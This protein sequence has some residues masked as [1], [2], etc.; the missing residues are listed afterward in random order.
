MSGSFPTSPAASSVNIKS[1]VKETSNW[2]GINDH[3]LAKVVSCKKPY[4]YKNVSYS[5]NKINIVAIDFGCKKNCQW[6]I[7]CL[8]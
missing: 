6:S 2:S 3:D 8:K 4:V 5:K 1:I 7:S